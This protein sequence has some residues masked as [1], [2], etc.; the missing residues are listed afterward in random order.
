MVLK[1]LYFKLECNSVNLGHSLFVRI[2]HVSTYTGYVALQ[3]GVY[4]QAQ[5]I[6]SPQHHHRHA[7]RLDHQVTAVRRES[8]RNKYFVTIRS[9]SIVPTADNILSIF[10]T[11]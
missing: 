5:T 1:D 8:A 3:H 11:V 9:R 7:L 4:H 10:C 6:G 2:I